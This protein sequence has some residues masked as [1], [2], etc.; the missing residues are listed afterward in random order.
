MRNL[1]QLEKHRLRDV[2][3]ALYGYNGDGREGV[4]TAC[5][6]WEWSMISATHLGFRRR[7]IEHKKSPAGNRGV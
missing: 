5:M 2:E 6:R 3:R 7:I 4:I 1:E